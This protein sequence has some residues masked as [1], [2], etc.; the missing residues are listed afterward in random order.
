MGYVRTEGDLIVVRDGY[1]TDCCCDVVST[2]TYWDGVKCLGMLTPGD[3]CIITGYKDSYKDRIF[4]RDDSFCEGFKVDICETQRFGIVFLENDT[5][6]DPWPALSIEWNHPSI[7]GFFHYNKVG[8]DLI[9]T[10]GPTGSVAYPVTTV[11]VTGTVQDFLSYFSARSSAVYDGYFTA[12]QLTFNGL[13][14]LTFRCIEN[15]QEFDALTNANSGVLVTKE[16]AI[17]LKYDGITDGKVIVY[18]LDTA[19]IQN[20]IKSVV[21]SHFELFGGDCVYNPDYASA[22]YTYFDIK[23]G[24]GKKFPKIELDYN[25][26]LPTFTANQDIFRYGDDPSFSYYSPIAGGKNY[27]Q[28][29][30]NLPCPFENNAGISPLAFNGFLECAP[31]VGGQV[32]VPQYVNPSFTG[33]DI[34]GLIDDVPFDNLNSTIKY[35]S[36]CYSLSPSFFLMGMEGRLY[37]NYFYDKLKHEPANLTNAVINSGILAS[38]CSYELFLPLFHHGI[39]WGP[40]G[41]YCEGLETRTHPAWVY[42]YNTVENPLTEGNPSALSVDYPFP[43]RRG[44]DY[45]PFATL[46]TRG[47]WLKTDAI[48]IYFVAR[49]PVP[50][51]VGDQTGYDDLEQLAQID[52]ASAINGIEVSTP[53]ACNPV[54]IYFPTS[55]KTIGEFVDAVNNLTIYGYSG[56]KVFEF[57]VG[58]DYVRS[59]PASCVINVSSEI[60]E[61]NTLGYTNNPDGDSDNQSASSIVMPKGYPYYFGGSGPSRAWNSV[62]LP[63]DY[64]GSTLGGTNLSS[65]VPPACRL[66]GEKLPRDGDDGF[67]QNQNNMWW[68]SIPVTKKDVLSISLIEPAFTY[69]TSKVATG[70]L[71]LS[72]Y[73]AV[74]ASTGIPLLRGGTTFTVDDLITEINAIVVTGVSTSYTPFSGTALLPY[75]YWLDDQTSETAG[76]YSYGTSNP[77]EHNYS[78]KEALLDTGIET[79]TTSNT[80]EGLHRRRCNYYITEYK[81]PYQNYCIPEGED[82]ISTENLDCDGDRQVVAGYVLSQGCEGNNCI[83]KWYL[84]SK[85]CECS[86]VSRCENGQP[87][88]LPHPFNQPRNGIN[89]TTWAKAG[90]LGYTVS[91][92]TLYICEYNF[93]PD[94]DIPLLVK[95]PF[96]VQRPDGSFGLQTGNDPDLPGAVEFCN[97]DNSLNIVKSNLYGWCQYIDWS[98]T[99][100]K[101]EDIPR[102][103]LPES[104][105]LGRTC[106]TICSTQPWNYNP[107]LTRVGSAAITFSDGPMFF[108]I[109]GGSVQASDPRYSVA[110]ECPSFTCY[111]CNS[112]DQMCGVGVVFKNSTSYTNACVLFRSV[113]K[114]TTV[115]DIDG[116]A[117]LTRIDIDCSTA[118]CESWF[119]CDPAEED[120]YYTQ[121]VRHP[122]TQSYSF[123]YTSSFTNPLGCDVL[124]TGGG[125]CTRG[126]AL[127][128]C[129]GLD[130]NVCYDLPLNTNGTITISHDWSLDWTVNSCG[131][132]LQETTCTSQEITQSADCGYTYDGCDGSSCYT[133]TEPT[134]PEPAVLCGNCSSL[135]LE[136]QG[137]NFTINVD[138]EI[139][140]YGPFCTFGALGGY[141]TRSVG[142]IVATLSSGFRDCDGAGTFNSAYNSSLTNT[143]SGANSNGVVNGSVNV[144]NANTYSYTVGARTWATPSADIPN[145]LIDY[146]GLL[147]FWND[148]DFIQGYANYNLLSGSGVDEP[149]LRE[150]IC[151]GI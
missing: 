2:G 112:W 5:R 142:T 122:W 92:P 29:G 10:F 60:F 130:P 79:F 80:L 12:T 131:C 107:Q 120:G 138:D 44:F 70:R 41:S 51:H 58:S 96:L 7:S 124:G 75:D 9:A 123:A 85:R 69:A 38:N 35:G 111:S 33:Y 15:D 31:Q 56:V 97:S 93:H 21:N 118:C 27:Y 103:D 89:G 67:I 116:S 62:G 57:A 100:V 47:T 20:R 101:E 63:T 37:K 137:G 99:R 150:P 22:F 105:V 71:E 6:E 16:P 82:R 121:Q 72:V 19:L 117:N 59:L 76:I 95:V 129:F 50:F 127:G 68:T 65:I 86:T 4:V 110:N 30:T 53:S 147:T 132:T 78:Y 87:E 151:T 13:Q 3:G 102:N 14:D 55:G 42:P 26:C 81:D 113:L 11:A 139:L 133:V 36:E 94:C 128:V 1:F 143:W 136:L 91:Q 8:T 135:P 73:G 119:T 28:I 134:P 140:D 45:R 34:N 61:L 126:L 90:W 77:T 32:V 46:K 48:E 88:E 146:S 25:L 18:D 64:Y 17:Y 141:T 66:L 144:T 54:N 52:P 108:T 49:E 115:G 145:S 23:L 148:K 39:P 149:R 106:G 43:P 74:T 104:L 40:F 109:P 83:T 125:G 98:E 24:C 114:D 84:R